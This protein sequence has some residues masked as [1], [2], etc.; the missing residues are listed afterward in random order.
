M[1][2][3]QALK[4]AVEYDKL[5]MTE[6]KEEINRQYLNDEIGNLEFFSLASRYLDKVNAEAE[7]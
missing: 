4:T 5:P 1:S 2:S 6:E 7:L 3:E